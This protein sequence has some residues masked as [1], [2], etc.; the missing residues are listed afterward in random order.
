MRVRTCFV[1]AAAAAMF[2]AGCSNALDPV[3][4]GPI[5][6][7]PRSLSASEQALIEHSNAFGLELL[8]TVVG[9]D[10]RPNVVLSPLSASMALGMTLNGARTG[11][12]DAMRSTLGFD[13]LSQDEINAAYRDLIDLLEDLDPNVRFAIANALW[14]NE[15]ISFRE[16][17]FQAVRESF[18]A[19]AA[20]RSFADPATLQEINAWVA[21]RTDGLIDAILGTLDPELAMLLVNAIYFEGAWISR[22]GTA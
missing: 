22:G 12:F 13:D 2:A 16:A 9:E 10:D 11:T 15:D 21:D 3:D 1:A 20:S 14:A 7:L 8:R 4:A 5:D 17:F 6:S 18:D 19:E